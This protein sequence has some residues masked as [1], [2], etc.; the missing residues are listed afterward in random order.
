VDVTLRSGIPVAILVLVGC[1]SGSTSVK[2]TAS[3]AEAAQSAGST[4]SA[5]PDVLILDRSAV[6]AAVSLQFEQREG[7]AV[8]LACAGRMVVAA[9]ATYPCDGATADGEEIQ[10]EVRLT[11]DSG[12]YTWGN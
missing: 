12:A 4:A 7:V 9:G 5:P 11:D 3:A 1:C 10:I 8:N 2:G 6:E